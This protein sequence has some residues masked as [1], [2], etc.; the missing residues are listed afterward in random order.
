MIK[1]FV[2]SLT[3][4]LLFQYL[5]IQS[6]SRLTLDKPVYSQAQ[7]DSLE[8]CL[9]HLHPNLKVKTLIILAYGYINNDTLKSNEYISQGLSLA[10][11]N[12]YQTDKAQ[13]YIEKGK[14]LNKQGKY[15]EGINCFRTAFITYEENNNKKEMAAIYNFIGQ[16]YYNA[17]EYIK[18]VQY[19][20]L[21]YDLSNSVNDNEGAAI[22][23]ND[24]GIVNYYLGNYDV[25]LRFYLK[26]LKIKEKINNKKSIAISYNNLSLVYFALKN[27]DES[28]KYLF[29]ASDLNNEMKEFGGMAA[30][31]SNIANI[32]IEQ[33]NTQMGYEFSL[34]AI[35]ESTK[36]DNKLIL[37]HSYLN[38]GK[39]FLYNEEPITAKKYLSLAY[40][41]YNS[42]Q[43]PQGIAE[44]L[45]RLA[46]IN[47]NSG[48]YA[49]AIQQL[50]DALAIASKHHFRARIKECYLGLSSVYKELG[51]YKKGLQYQTQYINI[52][53]SLMNSDKNKQLMAIQIAYETEKK[54][55]EIE[56]LRSEKKNDS[57]IKL[58]L[59]FAIISGLIALIIILNRYTTNK[60]AN[61]ILQE[62]NF[63]IVLQKEELQNSNLTKDKFFSIIAHDLKSPFQGLLGFTNYIVDN[64]EF[65]PKSEIKSYMDLLYKQ[66]QSLYDLIENLLEWSRLQTKGID[67]NFAL[68]D[69]NELVNSVI[70]LSESLTKKKA[71]VINNNIPEKTFVFVD[72]YMINSTIHNL[73]SNAIKFTYKNGQININCKCLNEFVEITIEDNGVGINKTDI[74][75][76]F[77]MDIHFTT[78]GTEDE[79]GTGLG[80]IL[81][82]EFIEKNGGAIWVES[83]L[84][85]GTKFIFTLKTTQ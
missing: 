30:I 55:R 53:D 50:T 85:K 54:T 58:Y 61:K 40:S 57:L 60:K 79:K 67:I 56:I 39:L 28:L 80:L 10:E 6:Q 63:K 74:G 18:A 20:L 16:S 45:N 7:L 66:V 64:F 14:L 4:I 43:A 12:D 27:Y 84:N 24:L 26:S 68:I 33:K 70:R 76:L 49:L 22:S 17:S 9:P 71:I 31:L 35:E 51:D 72:K 11:K 52:S 3:I 23:A 25:S 13:L 65:I 15:Y 21:A 46:K 47:I 42:L 8:K 73:I 59:W 29:K 2:L 36:R 62:K 48:F 81:A 37:A 82:K 69:L 75:K 38:L 19:Y 1:H 83:E 44:S 32:Y 77:R 41:I 5:T 78:R 34:K